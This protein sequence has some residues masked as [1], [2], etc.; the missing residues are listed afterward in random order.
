M[1]ELCTNVVHAQKR[2]VSSG[3]SKD[4]NTSKRLG[5]DLC[6][7]IWTRKCH[8]DICVGSLEKIAD[9]FC[10]TFARVSRRGLVSYWIFAEDLM[11]DW[12]SAKW[13]P[14]QI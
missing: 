14:Q 11:P 1:S 12:Q 2:T 4:A 9:G 3:L 5:V 8:F 13:S 10:A 7:F 6:R